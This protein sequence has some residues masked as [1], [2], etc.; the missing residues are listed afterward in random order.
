MA[1]GDFVLAEPPADPHA[2]QLWLQ[3]AAGLILFE[4]V[5]GYARSLVDANAPENERAAAF[6]A[7]DDTVYGVMRVIDGIPGPF[8]GNG[9][10]ISLQTRVH[11]ESEIDGH[12]EEELDLGAGDGMAIGFHGWLEGDFGE[13]PLA[14]PRK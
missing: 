1:S 12:L 6:A 14:S 10:S 9:R 11:L 7:I 13:S 8:R 2:R 4:D 5:R 3:H